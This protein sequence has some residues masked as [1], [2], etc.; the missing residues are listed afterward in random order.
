VDVKSDRRSKALIATSI[1][2]TVLAIVPFCG[3]VALVLCLTASGSI[4][5]K[6]VRS[7][8][9]WKVAWSAGLIVGLLGTAWTAYFLAEVRSN[10]LYLYWA[11]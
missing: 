3:A 1:P 7:S 2:F 10:G 5:D 9:G 4:R 8:G 6:G 11:T